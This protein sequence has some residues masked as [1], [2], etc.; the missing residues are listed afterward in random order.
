[1]GSKNRAALPG[2]RSQIEFPRTTVAA[3]LPNQIADLA[4]DRRSTWF[5][6]FQVQNK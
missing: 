2:E 1:M 3:H 5:A 6:T 4:G